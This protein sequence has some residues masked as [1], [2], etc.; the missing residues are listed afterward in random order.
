MTY[1]REDIAAV[2]IALFAAHDTAYSA[3]TGSQWIAVKEPYTPA[4]FLR[5][6]ETRR[7][8]SGYIA[9][10]ENTSHVGALDFDT[11]DGWE[12]GLR[13]GQM[14]WEV[15]APS[16]IERSRRGCHLWLVSETMP[17]RTW[18]RAL[19]ASLQITDIQP[20]P[21]IE[22]R[23][24]QDEIP[25][26]GLGN[27]LR[28]P[29]MPHQKTGKRYPLSDPRT[30]EPTGAG[31]AEMLLAVEFAPSAVLE[32][33]AARYTPV[34]DPRHVAAEYQRPSVKGV[35]DEESA[36]EILQQL[37]G[38]QARPGKV[39]RCPAHEDKHPSLSVL[40]DDKRVI[41]HAVTCELNNGG[42]GV[43]TY[44]LRK[45]GFLRGANGSGKQEA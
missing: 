28:T 11:E 41:C 43:G 15:G 37:W 3:W 26:G 39:V 18:R 34:F 20:N 10:P 27:A 33:L 30:G 13:V 16:Y 1:A 14:F 38:I 42:H 40:P 21:K 32:S 6:I 29:T 44:Q 8:V 35:P 2:C 12:Q 31:L 22:I 24:G 25:E 45:L 4:V 36:T 23:P 19:T 17:M 9:T 7:P 5:A